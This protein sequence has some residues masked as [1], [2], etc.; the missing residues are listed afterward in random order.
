MLVIPVADRL[1]QF[2]ISKSSKLRVTIS[3]KN[4]S[5]SSSSILRICPNSPSMRIILLV[6][7]RAKS[8]EFPIISNRYFIPRLVCA[9]PGMSQRKSRG[10][11]TDCF[12]AWPVV[13]IQLIFLHNILELLLRFNSN[14]AVI[15]SIYAWNMCKIMDQICMAYCMR[16]GV[17]TFESVFPTRYVCPIL[18]GCDQ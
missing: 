9:I 4:S 5:C 13:W 16:Y 2:T 12:T 11:A 17:S 7:R 14:Q 8:D 1:V 3:N 18:W 15:L 10:V 6:N